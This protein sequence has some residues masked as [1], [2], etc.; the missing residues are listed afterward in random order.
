MLRELMNRAF[1]KTFFISIFL[2]FSLFSTLNAKVL[3]PVQIFLPGNFAGKAVNLSESLQ[4]SPE[5][6]WKAPSLLETFRR[7]SPESLNLVFGAGN[8]SSIFSITSFAADGLAEH[9]L[10]NACKVEAAGISP[11]DLLIFRNSLLSKEIRRRIFTNLESEEDYSVFPSHYLHREKDFNIWFFNFIGESEFRTLP[12]QNWSQIKPENPAR[13]LRRLNPGISADD[14][15]VTTVHMN[16]DQVMELVKEFN[17]FP[18]YHLIVDV[19]ASEEQAEFSTIYP[20]RFSRTFVIS[21]HS[22][23]KKLP[24]LRIVRR[25]NGYPRLS[26]KMLPYAKAEPG[27][28]AN[29]FTKIRRQLGE[30]LYETLALITTKVRPS[31][32]PFRFIPELYANF[33][34]SYKRA[35]IAI[36][37]PPDENHKIDNVINPA[38]LFSSFANEKIYL[39]R[40]TGFNLEKLVT[41]IMRTSARPFPAFSGISFQFVADRINAVQIGKFPFQLKRSYNLAVNESLLKDPVNAE[42]FKNIVLEPFDGTTLWDVWKNQVKSLRINSEHLLD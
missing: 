12:L 31:T 40:L 23:H 6:C 35:D 5:V 13:S 15:S 18:G 37:L 19:A 27:S 25:N 33:C 7:F 29:E 3:Q 26:L 20:E 42:F 2:S 21:I 30:S 22:G 11:D 41:E 32:A 4:P 9:S 39:C 36:I 10:I 34:R 38:N 28:A 24:M 17:Q 14:L 1:L 16:K 8:D